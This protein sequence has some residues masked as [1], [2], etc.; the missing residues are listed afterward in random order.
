MNVHV[1]GEGVGGYAWFGGIVG[2]LILFAVCGI[3]V[4]Y[5]FMRSR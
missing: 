3:I 5:R 1:P 2:V 4:T